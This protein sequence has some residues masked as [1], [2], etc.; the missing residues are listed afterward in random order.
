MQLWILFV[1]VAA[2][3]VI[4]NGS[5]VTAGAPVGFDEGVGLAESVGQG[6]ACVC[7]ITTGFIVTSVAAGSQKSRLL[8]RGLL[9][10]AAQI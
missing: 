7:N 8:V 1:V 3:A 10:F 6:V 9:P 2:A 4:R 5:L